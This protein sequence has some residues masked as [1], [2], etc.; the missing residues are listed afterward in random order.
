VIEN[1]V[2]HKAVG[3]EN[4]YVLKMVEM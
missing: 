4:A 2:N 3:C 1:E